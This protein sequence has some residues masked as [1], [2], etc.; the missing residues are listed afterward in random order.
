MAVYTIEACV[1]PVWKNGRF[2]GNHTFLVLRKDN[3]L[4]HQMHIMAR[5][6][7]TGAYEVLGKNGRTHTLSFV[8]IAHDKNHVK[9]MYGDK[10][11]DEKDGFIAAYGSSGVK[12]FVTK[13][14]RFATVYTSSDYKEV[15]GRWKKGSEFGAHFNKM[16][17]AYPDSRDGLQ[18]NVNNNAGYAAL[19]RFMNL[20]VYDF[21]GVPQPGLRCPL[22][23]RE[24]EKFYRKHYFSNKSNTREETADEKQS[25]GKAQGADDSQPRNEAKVSQARKTQEAQTRQQT[26]STQST[27]IQN[28]SR[29]QK[30]DHTHQHG[31]SHTHGRSPARDHSHQH[32]GSSSRHDHSH[33]HSTSSHRHGHSPEKKHAEKKHEGKKHDEKI[34]DKRTRPDARQAE[35]LP[36][37]SELSAEH[38]QAYL[39]RGVLKQFG[40]TPKEGSTPVRFIAQNAQ[41]QTKVLTMYQVADLRSRPGSTI[42]PEQAAKQ[43]FGGILQQRQ[44]QRQ[45]ELDRN[46]PDISM[47]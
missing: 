39:P 35:V 24:I 9:M 27:R 17:I 41:G 19:S 31:Q 5:N 44:Q 46:S 4:I 40:L 10:V 28:Q 18:N 43:F 25:P 45:A 42:N 15:L 8:Q 29:S 16:K 11:P 37:Y 20:E 3:Q 6:R 23:L 38:K 22:E 32:P 13:D 2:A 14:T 47:S 26:E 30:H 34:H 12:S 7:E 1:R 33:K 21:K 36:R